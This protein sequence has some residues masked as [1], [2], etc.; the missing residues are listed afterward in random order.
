L[1]AAYLHW[2]CLIICINQNI[3]PFGFPFVISRNSMISCHM[4]SS[5]FCFKLETHGVQWWAF[6][7][8]YSKD[9]TRWRRVLTKWTIKDPKWSFYILKPNQ[10]CWVQANSWPWFPRCCIRMRERFSFVW[11]T[12]V[13]QFLIITCIRRADLWLN[14]WPQPWHLTVTDS[15]VYVCVIVFLTII[16]LLL[17]REFLW[18][19]FSDRSSSNPA[20]KRE[21]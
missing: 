3:M 7:P 10:G 17:L 20:L 4:T 18:L 12:H 19:T 6:F 15:K 5:S 8:T 16:K 2:V 13:P 11:M 14:S 9:C 21:K 1:E